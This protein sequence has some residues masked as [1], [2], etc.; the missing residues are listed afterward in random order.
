MELYRKYTRTIV[1]C[2]VDNGENFSR[3][4]SFTVC[5][6]SYYYSFD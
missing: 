3:K 5:D 4:N 6:C 2:F 1:V